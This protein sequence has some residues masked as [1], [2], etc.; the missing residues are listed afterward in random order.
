[1]CFNLDEE[2]KFLVNGQKNP[3]PQTLE[4]FIALAEK[5]EAANPN[6]GLKNELFYFLRSFVYDNIEYNSLGDIV[7]WEPKETKLDELKTLWEPDDHERARTPDGTDPFSEEEK[8]SLFYMLTHSI[9]RSKRNTNVQRMMILNNY[10]RTSGR[11]FNLDDQY[12]MEI[13]VVAIRGTN[14]AVSL[15]RVLRGLYVGIRENRQRDIGEFPRI[16]EKEYNIQN[17]M[18]DPLYTLTMAE[19][20]SLSS[21]RPE[22]GNREKLA[23]D[24]F[25]AS[26]PIGSDLETKD[27]CP[28]IYRLKNGT[29][30]AYSASSLRGAADGLILGKIIHLI[31][32]ENRN[33]K[34]SQILRMYYSKG[35]ILEKDEDLGQIWAS[36]C[37]RENIL[38]PLE[39][40]LKDQ[41]TLYH[42]LVA[43]GN[44]NIDQ[45]VEYTWKYYQ[46]QK[47]SVFRTYIQALNDYCT[48]E[49]AIDRPENLPKE[50]PL[51]V[52]AILDTSNEEEHLKR[53]QLILGYFAKGLDL[54]YSGSRMTILTDEKIPSPA[55]SATGAVNLRPIVTDTYSSACVACAV[56][57]ISGDDT[58][59]SAPE[60]EVILAID[61][62]LQAKKDNETTHN[63]VNGKVVIYFNF[64]NEDHQSRPTSQRAR[65]D[66]NLRNLHLR[67]KDV[68]I[69]ALG[70][71]NELVKKYAAGDEAFVMSAVDEPE[72]KLASNL[73]D[74]VLTAPATLQYINCATGKDEKSAIFEDFVTPN[75]IQHWSMPAKY[76]YKS[77]TLKITFESVSGPLRVCHNRAT[78]SPELQRDSCVDIATGQKKEFTH[79]NPCKNFDQYSCSPFNFA[80]LGVNITESVRKDACV[81]TNIDKQCRTLDQIKF[82]VS[83]TDVRCSGC[84]AIVAT[85]ILL[86][87]G[88]VA[89]NL[90]SKKY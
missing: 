56:T 85:P 3:L 51:D 90:L 72:D 89:L 83:H 2:G 81:N 68:A 71:S 1:M 35:G 49:Y 48:K 69:Y 84:S 12:P 67:H 42:L 61:Q 66:Q 40:T 36:F 38:F 7:R 37:N 17:K 45:N 23:Q 33:A 28:M 86:L 5:F 77:G 82:K 21:W 78:F 73:L 19:V 27:V 10:T 41:I 62:Y 76:F 60:D 43:N 22:V 16:I 70:R 80:V 65:V 47:T 14:V 53:Q 6:I 9:I 13:G 50:T 39:Q 59:A 29:T 74:K 63:G 55:A 4:N 58:Y 34:L 57:Q 26:A 8:C 24:G 79:S 31:N 11:Y 64:D 46:E 30:S 15:G 75:A 52:I 18:L 87:L 54:R 88:V 20:I 44:K 32:R 25:W